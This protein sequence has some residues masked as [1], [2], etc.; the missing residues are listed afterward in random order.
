[1][2]EVTVDLSP[3]A[4]SILELLDEGEMHPYELATKMRER[5]HDEFIRLNF[6]SLYHTVE[7]LERSGW[8]VPAEREKEGRRPERTIYRLTDSGRRVLVQV[9]GE[10]LAQPKREYPHFAAGLMFMHHLSAAEAGDHL[11]RRAAALGGVIEK[12]T[13]IMGELRAA[14]VRRLSIVELEHKIAMLEAERTWV[15][16]LE[17]EIRSGKLEW[18][19]GIESSHEG[20]RRRHG[21]SA[22]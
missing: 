17:Q 4:L 8:I 6:G 18:A 11:A 14:D 10:I 20:L 19:V 5:H 22:H 3:L 13:R 16:K 7:A 9:V 2:E 15:G 12:L 1:M 21:T